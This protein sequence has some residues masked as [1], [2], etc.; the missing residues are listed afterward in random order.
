MFSSSSSL[1]SDV[2]YFLENSY[3][4]QIRESNQTSGWFLIKKIKFK[5]YVSMISE[6]IKISELLQVFDIHK[7]WNSLDTIF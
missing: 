4:K 6:L 1:M 3:K 7:Y 2:D 5:S